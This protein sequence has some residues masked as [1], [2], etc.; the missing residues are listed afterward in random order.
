MHGTKTQNYKKLEPKRAKDEEE[1]VV[2]N[3]QRDTIIKAK[4]DY[5]FEYLLS[6]KAVS[7]GSKKKVIY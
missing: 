6:Y 5:Y 7:K 2:T 3:R 4:K 1:N